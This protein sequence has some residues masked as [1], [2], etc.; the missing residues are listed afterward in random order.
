MRAHAVARRTPDTSVRGTVASVT[1]LKS[2][3]AGRAAAGEHPA[4]SSC[5]AVLHTPAAA[6]IS[7]SS[8]SVSNTD[9]LASVGPPGQCQSCGHHVTSSLTTPV[10]VTRQ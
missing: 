1:S 8:T 9:N 7:S 10:V 3:G 6:V 5:P 2:A 4:G